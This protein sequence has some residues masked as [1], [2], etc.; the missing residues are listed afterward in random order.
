MLT[1]LD[2]FDILF[3]NLLMQKRLS[4]WSEI[5]CAEIRGPKPVK[6]MLKNECHHCLTEWQYNVIFFQKDEFGE[7]QWS[8]EQNIYWAS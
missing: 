4:K 1:T 5:P 2:L 3:V 7:C 6:V 8:Y